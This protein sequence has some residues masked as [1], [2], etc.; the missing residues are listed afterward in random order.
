MSTKTKKQYEVA[1]TQPIVNM[2]KVEDNQIKNNWTG[3]ELSLRCWNCDTDLLIQPEWRL[4]QCTQCMKLN[5]VP[6]SGIFDDEQINGQ[7]TFKDKVNDNEFDINF[8]VSHSIVNCPF[9]K[10]DNKISKKARKISCYQCKNVFS[11]NQ[12]AF[13]SST[14]TKVKENQRY[15]P[16]IQNDENNYTNNRHQSRWMP[17]YIS[18]VITKNPEE[19]ARMSDLY[20]DILNYPGVYPMFNPYSFYPIFAHYWDLYEQEFEDLVERRE[21]YYLFRELLRQEEHHYLHVNKP[22]EKYRAVNDLLSTHK[23]ITENIDRYAFIN[24]PNNNL[25]KIGEKDK[26]LKDY[27]TDINTFKSLDSLKYPQGTQPSYRY[28]NNDFTKQ[29]ASQYN[30]ELNYKK[31]DPIN[32][33]YLTPILDRNMNYE[34]YKSE[35]GFRRRYPDYLLSLQKGYNGK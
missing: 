32:N 6:G 17:D 26:V 21:K 3:K 25:I 18:K 19:A 13:T 23:K 1:T 34:T 7:L 5:R 20:P 14:K 15:S 27:S 29:N 10:S 22:K 16:N 8:P 12:E 9:C 31:E 28:K 30:N 24:A 33:K 35:N 11:V 4:V 2:D